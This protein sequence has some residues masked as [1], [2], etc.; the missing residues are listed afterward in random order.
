MIMK[1]MAATCAAFLLSGCA[2]APPC[3]PAEIKIPIPVPCVNEIPNKPDSMMGQ[4]PE[5]ATDFDKIQ[6]LTIDYL[7][8]QQYIHSLEA[9][10]EGCR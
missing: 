2:S 1:W 10:I 6:A 8:Q 9:V 5:S 3:E 4:L 7:S